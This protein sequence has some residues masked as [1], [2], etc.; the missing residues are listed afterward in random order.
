MLDVQ[1]GPPCQEVPNSHK[2]YSVSNHGNSRCRLDFLARAVHGCIDF[3]HSLV[4]WIRS[5]ISFSLQGQ[6]IAHGG[7]QSSNRVC[8]SAASW[9]DLWG[10]LLESF[11]QKQPKA[12][13]GKTSVI[14]SLEA[15]VSRTLTL[16]TP[17]ICPYLTGQALLSH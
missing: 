2:L 6:K 14:K 11:S 10:G 15:W 13:L 17:L 8:A 3:I 5:I 4:R 1:Q 9:W 7:H 16:F 12:H